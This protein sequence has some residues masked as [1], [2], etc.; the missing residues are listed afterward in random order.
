MPYQAPRIKRTSR[1]HWSLYRSN[2]R[3]WILT[4]WIL[5]LPT[6]T[7]HDCIKRSLHGARAIVFSVTVLQTSFHNVCTHRGT[8]FVWFYCQCTKNEGDRSNK[9]KF[10][11]ESGMLVK[12]HI[13]CVKLRALVELARSVS[14][15]LQRTVLSSAPSSVN[16]LF[17]SSIGGGQCL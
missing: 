6:K 11:A 17:K 12:I 14:Q 7:T 3:M 10:K 15:H 5:W 16:K 13:R 9:E 2:W 4:R 8:V 1:N